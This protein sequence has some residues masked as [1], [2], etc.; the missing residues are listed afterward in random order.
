MNVTD[1]EIKIDVRSP[2]HL[3]SGQEDV[4]LDAEVVHD[5][6]GLPYFPA[7]RFKGLLYESALEVSEM[8]ALSSCDLI[9]EQTL[10]EMFRHDDTESIVQLII[11][12][13]YLKPEKE[14]TKLR[15]ELELLQKAYPELLRS[16][17]VLDA[18]TSVRYQ[19]ALE[20]G[21]AQKGTLHNMRVVDSDG[22]A[23]YGTVQLVN[24]EDRHLRAFA[25]ALRNLSCAGMKRNR[26]FG[27]IQC[28]MTDTAKEHELLSAAL[29]GEVE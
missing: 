5:T 3:G 22:V 17:D 4:N 19:T 27:R 18:Y 25:L 14:Y 29:A 15:G 24:G 16:S 8:S 23:F 10:K 13:F 7:K 11:S 9:S 6:C 21:V 12:D 2:I 26:G 28:S 20:N 1:I